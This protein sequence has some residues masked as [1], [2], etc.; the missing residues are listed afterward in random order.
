MEPIEWYR[1]HR[2]VGPRSGNLEPIDHLLCE[3]YSITIMIWL[4][5]FMFAHSKS[6]LL[7]VVHAL[8]C[9]LARASLPFNSCIELKL[10]MEICF[11]GSPLC[12]ERFE[13]FSSP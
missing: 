7:E 5:P 2:A 4:C 10:Y 1:S 9:A 8:I 3:R 13:I 11:C 6:S 12:G